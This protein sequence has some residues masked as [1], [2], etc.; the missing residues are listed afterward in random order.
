M[1]SRGETVSQSMVTASCSLHSLL[2][3]AGGYHVYSFEIKKIS[4]H[5][6]LR[7]SHIDELP[8]IISHFRAWFMKLYFTLVK[9]GFI[10]IVRIRIS[11]N[12]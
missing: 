12:N 5:L 10:L 7:V 3:A 11:Q 9:L 6:L 2:P 8:S 4:P 1:Y